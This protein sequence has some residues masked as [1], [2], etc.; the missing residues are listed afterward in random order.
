M[1]KSMV[2]LREFPRNSG[3]FG[4][5]SYNV[6][7]PSS[8][9]RLKNKYRGFLLRPL[10]K[11]RQF[12]GSLH[13]NDS[14]S[15]PFPLFQRPRAKG[16]VV[17]SQF[18]DEKKHVNPQAQRFPKFISSPIFFMDT[19]H[20][21]FLTKGDAAPQAYDRLDVHTLMLNDSQRL[22]SYLAAIRAHNLQAG[23]IWMDM[24]GWF[25]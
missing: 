5:V 10:C 23:W 6:F 12:V 1:L 21:R 22:G 15:F 25:G 4:L 17:T 8:G 19:E 9:Q 14:H 3:L 20:L 24:D 7:W 18:L 11:Q 16:L 2:I 13:S